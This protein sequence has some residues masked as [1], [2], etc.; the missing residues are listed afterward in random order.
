MKNFFFIYFIS[1]SNTKNNPKSKADLS[2]SG[3]DLKLAKYLDDTDQKSNSHIK[4]KFDQFSVVEQT[5][6]NSKTNFQTNEDYFENTFRFRILPL[7]QEL[8]NKETANKNGLAELTMLMCS[9]CKTNLLKPVDN[10]ENKKYQ[11]LRLPDN[12][13]DELA[14]NFFCHLHSH[15]TGH[16]C[17]SDSTK[18]AVL[19]DSLNPLRETSKQMR[20][21]I[22]DNAT[23]FVLN[24]NHLQTEF[25]KL[26]EEHLSFACSNCNYTLGYKEIKRPNDFFLWK[27]NTQIN[28]SVGALDLLLN[29]E[30]GRYLFETRSKP[31]SSL[32]IYILSTDIRFKHFKSQFTDIKNVSYDLNDLLEMKTSRKLMYKFSDKRLINNNTVNK[33]GLT[34]SELKDLHND[35]NV[36]SLQ[37]SDEHYEFLLSVLTES[38]EQ[39]CESLK[40]SN[41]FYFALI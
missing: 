26:N 32:Y 27:S 24:E 10:L 25:I 23:I 38:T 20:K 4:L 41:D 2:K 40:R 12:E 9:M 14:D 21:S 28:N 18:E 6:K 19:R 11:V 22:L 8:V 29:L 30:T 15:S 5:F 13:I 16:S 31:A 36:N 7:K 33:Q 34:L 1:Q 35:F 39:L 3:I 17:D 37:V